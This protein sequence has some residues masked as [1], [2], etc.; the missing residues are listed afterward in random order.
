MQ[1]RT[2][3]GHTFSAWDGEAIVVDANFDLANAIKL[4]IEEERDEA[5]D[6]DCDYELEAY[7]GP[8]PYQQAPPTA[9]TSAPTPP[10][11]VPATTVPAPRGYKKRGRERSHALRK[12][13]RAD[14]QVPAEDASDCEIRASTRRKHIDPAQPISTQL[15]LPGIGVTRTGYTS[16]RDAPAPHRAYALHEL[17]GPQSKFD[18][19]LVAWE[20]REARPFVDR[21]ERVFGLLAGCP[22][23]APDWNAVMQD[24]ADTIDSERPHIRFK[25]HQLL[26]RRGP[27]PAT[28]H[29]HSYGGGQQEPMS[30][31]EPPAN[32]PHFRRILEHPAMARISGYQNGVT[33]GWAPELHSFLRMNRRILRTQQP[34]LRHNF[35]S[36]VWSATTVNYGPQTATLPHKDYANLPWGWCPITALGNFDPKRGG[37]LV[38]W[39]LRLVVEFPPGSTIIIPSGLITHSNV[40]VG[41]GETRF[42]VTQYTAG[43]LIRWIDQGFQT[44]EAFLASLTRKQRA[45]EQEKAKTRY[46]KGLAMFSTLTELRSR[47]A[48]EDSDSDLTDLEDDE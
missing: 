1:R 6:E 5:S 12:R 28:P 44:K 34:D 35:R 41:P 47:M 38:L 25:T 4:S 40:P 29:G 11:S 33:L 46:M 13:K 17:V 31:S 32:A 18:F 30:I 23:Q 10:H 20:G 9:A 45:A 48:H 2:R 16:L 27:F 43:A 21:G 8:A 37:H 15:S 39:E 24:F 36:S 19:D 7:N 42:S 3:S 22:D 14:A 26:H